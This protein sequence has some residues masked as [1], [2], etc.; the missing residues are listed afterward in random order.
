MTAIR[1]RAP[2]CGNDPGG[3]RIFGLSLM[4]GHI[5]RR[6]TWRDPGSACVF[7]EFRLD[8]RSRI[9]IDIICVR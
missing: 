3:G 9:N 7:R 5:L 6:K 4:P 2:L 8:D 1:A